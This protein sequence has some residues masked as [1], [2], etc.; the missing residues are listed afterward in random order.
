MAVRQSEAR[1]LTVNV[2]NTHTRAVVWSGFRAVGTITWL[3]EKSAPLTLLK[4]HAKKDGTIV[5]AG[6]VP[7]KKNKLAGRLA[8]FADVYIFRKDFAAL[9]TI[10]PKPSANV[11]DDRIAAALG[12]AQLSGDGPWV[13]VDAGTAVTVNA[14]EQDENGHPLF[15]GG[16]IF[17]GAAMSLAAMHKRTAQLPKLT[18]LKGPKKT[19]VFIGKSTGE[20][21]LNGVHY[22]VIGGVCECI[23]GQLE[24]LGTA[25][26]IVLTG[27]GLNDDMCSTVQGQFPGLVSVQPQLVHIGL[28]AAWAAHAREAR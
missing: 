16:L 17:P 10:K 9:I 25:A 18:P 21:M 26:R 6:V 23:R 27:G 20:A 3:T 12:A 11:G 8:S 28:R 14:V 24:E 15:S 4:R 7:A 13:V 22:A 2:G 19:S 5:L 1:V